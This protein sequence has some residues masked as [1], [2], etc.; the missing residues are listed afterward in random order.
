MTKLFCC[1]SRLYPTPIA[2]LTISLPR[3]R[4]V[5]LATACPPSFFLLVFLFLTFCPYFVKKHTA[6]HNYDASIPNYLQ[7]HVTE[8]NVMPIM[9]FKHPHL[10]KILVLY[11]TM[12]VM[13]VVYLNAVITP[14]V[15]DVSYSHFKRMVLEKRIAA[16]GISSTSLR[17]FYAYPP[18]SI[19]FIGPREYV[20]TPILHDPEL[21]SFLEKNNIEIVV[22]DENSMIVT[23]LS[24][25]T[26]TLIFFGFWL[27]IQRKM[28][29]AQNT[30]MQIGKHKAKIVA[31]DD[32]A[33]RFDDIAGQE[34]AKVELAEVVDFLK[35]PEKFKAMG[36]RTPKGVLLVGPP[37]TGKTLIAKAIAGEAEVPFFAISG[38]DFIEMF[39]GVGAA[40]VRDLFEQAKEKAP[41][42]IF[43][44][45][46]DSIGR[47]RGGNGGVIGGQDEREQTLNQLLVEMDG[48]QQA[49]GVLL[50]ASTNRPE[51]LDP[52]LLRPGRFDRQVVLDKPDFRERLAILKKHLSKIQVD[53]NLNPE[54]IGK[55]TAGFSG[56]DL[57]NLVNE[58]T[59]LAIRKQKNHID[60]NDF[61]EALERLITGVEKKN[62]LIDTKEKKTISIHEAGHAIMAYIS[63]PSALVQKVTIIPRGAGTLGFTLQMPPEDKYLYTVDDLYGQIDVLLGG[64][65][66]E[67]LVQEKAT[68][69]AVND[70]ERATSIA[71]DMIT[72]YGMSEA[73]GLASYNESK[74]MFLNPGAG[75]SSGLS[76]RAKRIVD[77]EIRDILEWRIQYC[78]KV[79]QENIVVLNNLSSTLFDQETLDTDALGHFFQKLT[80]KA[81]PTAITGRKKQPEDSI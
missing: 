49:Q 39:V 20:E 73:L 59:I 12:A 75:G 62:R 40:R 70:L 22:A 50:L 78:T 27:L 17:G 77:K 10:K 2:H 53:Q 56:A 14:R 64:R 23:L 51:I 9:K 24:W 67:I 81:R 44:D 4:R 63:N 30:M 35:C 26:P 18:K 15:T 58:A 21:L 80:R 42:I 29:N 7:I 71:R 79:L 72:R 38:S 3:L 33:V 57:A 41:C 66:A 65:A 8:G 28:G 31:R 34:E 13:F 43:I 46:I 47:S 68:T 37:G 32:I 6:H 60:N 11:T 36:A 52:A 25:V 54:T 74:L 5:H 76:E 61:D 19:P 1:F 16:A 48:F 55:R 45:E 69:G